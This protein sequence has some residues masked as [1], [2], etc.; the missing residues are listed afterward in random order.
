MTFVGPL[1]SHDATNGCYV[2]V[3]VF[4]ARSTLCACMTGRVHSGC[5]VSCVLRVL[6]LVPDMFVS[7][8]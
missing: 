5:V 8:S 7:V 4:V 2:H 1:T 3:Y 6:V